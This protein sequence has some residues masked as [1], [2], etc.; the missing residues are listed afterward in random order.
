MQCRT[1][2]DYKRTYLLYFSDRGVRECTRNFCQSADPCIHNPVP[3]QSCPVAM[4]LRPAG[5]CAK[6]KITSFLVAVTISTLFSAHTGCLSNSLHVTFCRKEK[7]VISSISVAYKSFHFSLFF[8]EL[9][10]YKL[11]LIIFF[12]ARI[13]SCSF[14]T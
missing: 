4:V 3:T 14:Y 13:S 11:L 8:S 1:V 6:K 7:E 5:S 10:T 2:P 12:L 9:F